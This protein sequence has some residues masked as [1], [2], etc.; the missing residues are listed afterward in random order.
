MDRKVLQWQVALGIKE[1][2]ELLQESTI[3]GE[4][5]CKIAQEAM[6]LIPQADTETRLEL[7]KIISTLSDKN[8]DMCQL[9]KKLWLTTFKI[10]KKI[11]NK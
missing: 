1:P 3:T 7:A 8:K 9:E 11:M 4:N 10:V 2:K 6:N 5:N